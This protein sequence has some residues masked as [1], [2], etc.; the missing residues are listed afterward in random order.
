MGDGSGSGREKA[1]GWASTLI[2]NA[3]RGRRFFRGA[4]DCGSVNFAESMPYIQALTWYDNLYG[5]ETL[6]ELG[7]INVHVLTD[8]QVIAHWGNQAMSLNSDVPRK[9]LA[10]WASMREFR[11]VGYHCTFHWAPR[12]TTSL[13]WAADLM[14]GLSRIEI[15][16]AADPAYIAG[17]DPATRAANALANL[18]F[19]DPATGQPLEPYGLN[20]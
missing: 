20:P 5:R 6:N 14:A 19:Y 4:M 7:Y 17:G 9:Q 11:R 3:R 12:L 16:R 13:N 1:C 2:D 18:V 8:S 15:E 10:I